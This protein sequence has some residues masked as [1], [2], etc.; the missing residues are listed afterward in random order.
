MR[1]DAMLLCALTSTEST[2]VI[3]DGEEIILFTC[4][5]RIRRVLTQVETEIW[6]RE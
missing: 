6:S 5:C 1:C 4:V 2:H 3:A